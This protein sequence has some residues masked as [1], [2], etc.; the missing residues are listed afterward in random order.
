ML[1]PGD[2]LGQLPS[3]HELDDVLE[4][5][6]LHPPRADAP[7]VAEDR[8]PVGH[9]L[10][11]LEEVADVDDA[12]TLVLEPPDDLEEPLAVFEGERARRL[13]HDED[14]RLVEQGPGDLDDLLGPDAQQA[15]GD[16][17]RDLGVADEL[18]GLADLPPHGLAV[19]PAR[20]V[21]L[22]A[23]HD[24]LLD[25]HVRGQGE[26]LVD[27]GHASAQAVE[28]GGRGVGTP[29]EL[30]PAG[31]GGQGAAEDLHQGALAGAVLADEGVDLAPA[32]LE[33]DAVKGPGRAEAL[34]H[35]GHAEDGGCRGSGGHQSSIRERSGERRVR[36]SGASMFSSVAR[37]TPVSMTFS[38]VS[39]RRW[40][41]IVLTPR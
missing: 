4:P 21:D 23:E 31:V 27:H 29:V 18:E 24:V 32:E 38:T 1:D 12:D 33:A 40:A 9:A 25:R 16:V 8:E 36:I 37:T 2:E 15:D 14:A 28:G 20:R 13:V 3:D 7:T 22:A 39:P 11:L 6:P 19:E 35:P 30:H 26:L 10:D 5:R 34:A 17:E 41:T